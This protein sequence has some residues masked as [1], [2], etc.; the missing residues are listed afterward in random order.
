MP[1]KFVGQALRF[2]SERRRCAT[3]DWKARIPSCKSGGT[4]RRPVATGIAFFD[5]ELTLLATERAA[6]RRGAWW[7]GYPALQNLIG[8]D[9][10]AVIAEIRIP[11]RSYY[12]AFQGH[13]GKETFAPAVSVNRSRRCDCAFRSATHWACSGADVRA[14]RNVSSAGKCSHSPIIVENDHEIGHLR[15]DLKTPPRAAC[16]DK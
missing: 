9:R 14:D 6:K 16:S 2:A 10:P 11:L 3:S 1:K 15:T 4:S 7:R 8:S 5:F 12:C 13:T